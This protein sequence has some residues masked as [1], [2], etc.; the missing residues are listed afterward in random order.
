M[1][2]LHLV[3]LACQSA[4]PLLL[5][6]VV[7]L[8][9]AMYFDPAVRRA[10]R[11]AK[12]YPQYSSSV[13]II[14]HLLHIV[15]SRE[16]L[17]HLLREWP[18][19]FGSPSVLMLFGRVL[20]N[21]SD[22][23]SIEAVLS[24]SKHITKGRAYDFLRP[25]LGEGLLTSGGEKW[26]YRRK[27]LT[28]AFHFKILDQFSSH[29]E[30]QAA[31]LVDDLA[32][33]AAAGQ[34]A[35][36]D[37]VPAVS[38][39]TLR[40]I[41]VTAMGKVDF[42]TDSSAAVSEKSYFEA[43]HRVGEATAL[44]IVRPWLWPPPLFWLT[45]M[46]QKFR[47]NLNTLHGFTSKVIADRK[48]TLSGD[49]DD[50]AVAAGEAGAENSSRFKRKAR[51]RPFLDVLLN[52]Q[53]RGEDISDQDIREEVDTFMFEGHDTTSMAISWSLEL[54]G[55]HP[56]VQERVVEELRGAGGEDWESISRLPYLDR[57]FKECLRLRPSVPFISRLL[58]T[59]AVL[60]DGRILPATSMGNIH[61]FDL[62]RHPDHFPDPDRF[63]PDRFLP[64]VEQ[65]RHPFAYLPFSAGPRNCI[66]KRFATMEV[67][68]FLAAVV[69]RFHIRSAM[70]E[71]LDVTADLVLRP[72]DGVRL[73]LFAR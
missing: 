66:G 58:E 29:L 8:G 37:V 28:P 64:Q 17:F 20:F 4:L 67:K 45:P 6:A 56:E 38:R 24:S 51:L 69:R 68:L 1:A 57:V 44:R 32:E 70:P 11:I 22:P 46:Y 13:P 12:G 53:R 27:L 15:K 23:V 47:K 62:H 9:L 42:G 25:W 26:H 10:R 7:M 39:I 73:R 3:W 60:P 48:M 18:K 43:I 14:G 31:Q 72:R 61:I 63:D 34:G 2:L 19:M 65:A 52:A 49:A 41:C 71:H 35:A 21:L 36:V 50:T 16:E 33:L 55:R 40:S 59:D 5:L 54:L 30:E